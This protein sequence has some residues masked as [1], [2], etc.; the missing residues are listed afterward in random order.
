V[1]AG[2]ALLLAPVARAQDADVLAPPI[3]EE[4]KFT[5]K[6]SMSG[7]TEKIILAGGC[8]WCTEAVFERAEGV[9]DVVSGYA[10]GKTENPTYKEV[11]YGT[12]GHAEIIEVTFDPEVTSLEAMLH[13]FWQSH[14]PT[15]LNRQGNDVGTQYR[16][17]IYYFDDRQKGIV[18]KSI[19]E[20]QA[21]YGDKK[22]TTE[23]APAGKV[24]PAEDYHQDYFAKNPSDRYCRFVLVP[25]I[26]KLGDKGKKLI[27]DER[28]VGVTK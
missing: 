22:I 4:P 10:G 18:E 7:K 3:K 25:K 2:L 15:T 11:C 1:A 21:A 28:T 5:P 12:T 13:L 27:S 9:L 8:F 16:S 19:A 6:K 24:W 23:V 17:A 14:D 26:D 20:E